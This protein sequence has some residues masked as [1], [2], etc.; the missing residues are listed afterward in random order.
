MFPGSTEIITVKSDGLLKCRYSYFESHDFY[1]PLEGFIWVLGWG[2]LILF[3]FP[4]LMEHNVHY[5]TID[6]KKYSSLESNNFL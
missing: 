1:D 6:L 3:G 4:L 5:S 2:S